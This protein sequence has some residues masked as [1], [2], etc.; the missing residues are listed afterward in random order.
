[1]GLLG[2][3]AE[4]V[5]AEYISLSSPEMQTGIAFY[6]FIAALG[7]A[8]YAAAMK[9]A[10][11]ANK[12]RPELGISGSA[13]QM[14]VVAGDAANATRLLTVMDGSPIIG[15]LDDLTRVIA[16]GVVAALEGGAVEAM[17]ELRSAMSELAVM[18]DM[19]NYGIGALAI[20]RAVGPDVPE[21]REFGEQAMAAFKRMD[22]AL[23]AD[24]IRDALAT[25]TPDTAEPAT[26]VRAAAGG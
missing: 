25:S 9:Q 1:M 10:E 17:T 15:R 21:A 6:R 14:A 18:G 5:V 11:Q 20:I 13:V 7:R 8:D 24:Q 26:A 16:R 23:L 22:A 4:S 3:D 12:D 2:Q 19:L